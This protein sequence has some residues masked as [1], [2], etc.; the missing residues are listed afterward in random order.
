MDSNLHYNRVYPIQYGKWDPRLLLSF[1]SSVD[2]QAV[3][4]PK[5]LHERIKDLVPVEGE[6]L[7]YGLRVEEVEPRYFSS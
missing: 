1:L 7:K 6:S 5:I 2:Q 3:F 4:S